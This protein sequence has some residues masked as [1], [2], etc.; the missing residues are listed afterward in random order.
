V[1]L[2]IVENGL[3]ILSVHAV[4][5]LRELDTEA[6]GNLMQNWRLSGEGEG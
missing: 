2:P 5:V 6:G 3:H 1:A 4:T